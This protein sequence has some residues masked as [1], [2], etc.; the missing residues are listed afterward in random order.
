MLSLSE[1]SNVGEIPEIVNNFHTKGQKDGTT[2]YLV[3]RK[4]LFSAQKDCALA[5]I[6]K[7]EIPETPAT[8]V[9]A[10][11]LNYFIA[12]EDFGGQEIN[13]NELATNDYSTITFKNFGKIVVWANFLGESDCHGSQ[14][15]KKMDDGKIIGVKIDNVESLDD[16]LLQNP[17]TLDVFFKEDPF[18]LGEKIL[19]SLSYKQEVYDS[20]IKIANTDFD[21]IASFLL[22]SVTASPYDEALN[23]IQKMKNIFEVQIKNCEDSEQKNLLKSNLEEILKSLED[24][25]QIKESISEVSELLTLLRIRHKQFKDLAFQLKTNDPIIFSKMNKPN[26]PSEEPTPTKLIVVPKV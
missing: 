3:F 24:R 9:V 12:S 2:W 23:F 7:R 10:G 22:Q 20:I 25:E 26:V 11:G 16:E 1:F 14:I 18:F 4:G 6:L 13:I 17:V 5:Q 21:S 8:F 19:S 15:L